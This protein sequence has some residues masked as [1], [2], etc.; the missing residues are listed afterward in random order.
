MASGIG[1]GGGVTG[2]CFVSGAADGCFVSGPADGC[3][4]SGA[5]DG[6]FVSGAADGC[7]VSGAADGCF[8]SGAADGCFVSGAADGCSTAMVRPLELIRSKL[9]APTVTLGLTG[10]TTTGLGR[11]GSDGANTTGVARAI[12][13]G[14][15]ALGRSTLASSLAASC[16]VAPSPQ[17]D[18]SKSKRADSPKTTPGTGNSRADSCQ[19]AGASCGG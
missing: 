14:G 6:C 3:F 8:V 18:F 15:S 2:S 19:G 7:F 16:P 5:A 11:A 10:G 17:P 13:F 12:G 9:T 1:A 4:V